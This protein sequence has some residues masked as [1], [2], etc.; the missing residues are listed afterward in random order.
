MV[1]SNQLY[2]IK[3]DE[4][5][6]IKS[7]KLRKICFFG[8]SKTERY[9]SRG[10]ID[11]PIGGIFGC[12]E[13]NYYGYAG[14]TL[15]MMFRNDIDE[16][17]DSILKY[18]NTR[19][20]GSVIVYGNSKFRHLCQCYDPEGNE[21]NCW[22]YTGPGGP[23][24]CPD[25]VSEEDCGTGDSDVDNE[26]FDQDEIDD[27]Y[28]SASDSDDEPLKTDYDIIPDED[29]VLDEDTVPDVDSQ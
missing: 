4:D 7:P 14:E 21:V 10:D 24:E 29:S 17:G 23:E 28:E 19:D 26:N 5:G 15:S 1:L 8:V 25:Y 16:N 2:D 18:L 22:E 27:S 9:E 3:Y 13:D 12:F 11:I 6:V 20:D